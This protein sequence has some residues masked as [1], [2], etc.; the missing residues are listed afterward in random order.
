MGNISLRGHAGPLQ[1]G[2]AVGQG[3]GGFGVTKVEQGLR[4]KSVRQ[5]GPHG[6]GGFAGAHGGD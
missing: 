2:L 1:Q 6:G 5:T 3:A 4:E